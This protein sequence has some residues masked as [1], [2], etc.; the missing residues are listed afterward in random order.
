MITSSQPW[1]A[2][3]ACAGTDDPSF[4]APDAEGLSPGE[5]TR[6]SAENELIAKTR[7]CLGCPVRSECALLGWNED[8]GVY[9]GLGAG[10]RRRIDKGKSITS[11]RYI[12]PINPKR[13][14]AVQMV[15]DGYGFD[16]VA[17]ALGVPR[18]AV[19]TLIR[20]HLALVT[21]RN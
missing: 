10:E 17:L 6:L 2:R 3:A 11:T 5:H 1:M 18:T 9:G 8:D 13:D 16:D 7:F 20:E 19:N 21:L 4:F 12:R 15:V 14:D